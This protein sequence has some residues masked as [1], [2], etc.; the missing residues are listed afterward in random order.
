MPSQTYPRHLQGISQF[1]QVNNQDKLSQ[2]LSVL[3]GKM[4]VAGLHLYSAK[5]RGLGYELL[6]VTICES[7]K[8]PEHTKLGLQEK[9]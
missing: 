7:L 2:I 4:T 8:I 6:N 9:R 5:T 3:R 1:S